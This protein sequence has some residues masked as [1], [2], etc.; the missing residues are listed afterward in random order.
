MS[1]ELWCPYAF[2]GPCDGKECPA[3]DECE[4]REKGERDV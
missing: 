4:Y 3:W 1:E 2:W